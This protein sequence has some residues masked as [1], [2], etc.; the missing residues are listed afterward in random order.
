MN[1]LNIREGGMGIHISSTAR[2]RACLCRLFIGLALGC[3]VV[4]ISACSDQPEGVFTDSGPADGNETGERS[5]EGSQA[6]DDGASSEGL[7]AAFPLDA[8]EDDRT[9]LI[10]TGLDGLSPMDVVSPWLVVARVFRSLSDPAN[11]AD[12]EVEL[13]RYADDYP[14]SAHL[15]YLDLPVDSCRSWQGPGTGADADDNQPPPAISG[16]TTIILNT[17]SGPWHRLDAAIASEQEVI[18]QSAGGLP[19]ALPDEVSLSIPGSSFPTV[20]AYRLH[21]P[22]PVQRLLPYPDQ[23]V[24]G[25]TRLQWV[26][27]LNNTLIKIDW[28]AF[29]ENDEFAGFPVSCLVRDDGAFLPD[30]ETRIFLGQIRQRLEVRYS[31]IYARLDVINGIVFHQNV[32]I[33]E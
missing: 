13:A 6:D 9:G 22:E 23:A 11:G 24:S 26:R 16:G 4:Q 28:L 30:M 33:A 1:C 19:G 25:D 15:D 32:E 29:D 5:E 2:Y 12:G 27:G 7:L 18:Y 21:E 31:R 10:V 3:S 14:V 20:A 17:P 8:D